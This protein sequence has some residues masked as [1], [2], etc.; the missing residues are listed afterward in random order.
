MPSEEADGKGKEKIDDAAA[1][2]APSPPIPS[3]SSPAR[4]PSSQPPPEY[5]M[6]KNAYE[7][8][9]K[10]QSDTRPLA[11]QAPV[12]GAA[13]AR[14]A[15]EATGGVSA[16]AARTATQAPAPAPMKLHAFQKLVGDEAFIPA[17]SLKILKLIGVGSFATGERFFW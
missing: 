11:T 16:A 10:Q 17:S 8:L 15:P 5:A 2:S 4:Q 12:S 1:P 6:A 9:W 7:A 3:T 14:A 13:A